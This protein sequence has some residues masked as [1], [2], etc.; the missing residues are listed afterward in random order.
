M[1]KDNLITE[2]S[3]KITILERQLSVPNKIVK[4]SEFSKDVSAPKTVE[5]EFMEYLKQIRG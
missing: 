1:K 4:K 5:E 3:E 2:L